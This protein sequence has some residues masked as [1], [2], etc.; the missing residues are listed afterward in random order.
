MNIRFRN[1]I[2]FLVF[3]FATFLSSFLWKLPPYGSIFGVLILIPSAILFIAA[4]HWFIKIFWTKYTI[5]KL[6]NE[7]LVGLLSGL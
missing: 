2:L 5:D 6:F 1:F 3:G 4:M 7:I